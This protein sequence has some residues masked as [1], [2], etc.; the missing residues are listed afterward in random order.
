MEMTN[1]IY[2]LTKKTK[3]MEL[4]TPFSTSKDRSKISIFTIFGMSLQSNIIRF[5][6]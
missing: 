4:F 1:L 5:L 2:L 3:K 6:K